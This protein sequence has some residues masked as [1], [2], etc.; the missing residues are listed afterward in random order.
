MQEASVKLDSIR[1]LI[2][3]GQL[4]LEK[5]SPNSASDDEIAKSTAG[6]LMGRDGSTF[7]KI[8][9]LDKDMVLLLKNSDLKPGEYSK[10]T[11]F[12]DDKGKKGV[13]IVLMVSK[14][15][16]HR[17]NLKD[18]YN[19]ISARALEEKKSAALEKWFLAKIPTFYVM[20]AGD[21]KPC[22]NLAKW[23]AGGAATAGN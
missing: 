6:Q 14:S 2:S 19:R 12:T 23:Q 7:L 15:A 8:D 18:D 3:S 4:G 10:P 1:T 13:R 16:P 22:Q 17:E 5:P 21:Y 20:I 11:A 9:D